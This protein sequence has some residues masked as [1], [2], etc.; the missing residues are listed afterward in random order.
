IDIDRA[1]T[2]RYGV[3]V[4]DVQDVIEIAIGGRKITTTVEGR[5]RYPV[6]VRYDRE[7]RD[8]VDTLGNVLVSGSNGVQIP[9]ISLATI[10]YVRGPMV[11]KSE[12]TFLVN[13]V[14]FD[15]KPGVAEVTAVVDAG[16]YLKEK[17]ASGEL[18]LP[19]NASYIFAGSYENQVRSEKTMMIVIPVTLILVFLILYFQFRSVPTSLN[20][21]SGI[22]VAWSGGFLMLWLYSQPWFLDFNVFGVSMRHLFH[23]KPYNLSVAVW[24]GFLALFGIATNDGVIYSTYLNQVFK[25]HK[26]H[27][28]Q[29]IRLA[30]VEAG[31]K[32]IRPALMTSATAILALMPV[33]SSQGR[34]ADVMVPMALPIFGGMFLDLITVFVVPTIYCLEKEIQFKQR[35]KSS[36]LP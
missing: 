23:V 2:A 15:K 11:I 24:V 3:N 29:E 33:L 8:S 6:R 34:G 21:F 7:L 5:E 16:K 17:I 30:T 13:Y 12:N 27:S 19:L 20:V 35:V 4:Q 9:L 10:N 14:I 25:E 1:A 31:L 28:V 22:F 18:K 32:R 26:F 36:V